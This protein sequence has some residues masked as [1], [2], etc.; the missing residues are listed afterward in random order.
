MCPPLLSSAGTEY[1]LYGVQ[2]LLNILRGI[3]WEKSGYFPR[4]TWCDFNVWTVHNMQSF[5]VQCEFS[6]QSILYTSRLCIVFS[7]LDFT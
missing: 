2:L 6:T 4:I 1:R 3:E 7:R 5:S